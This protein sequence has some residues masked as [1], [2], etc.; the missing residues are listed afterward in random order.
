MSVACANAK[1]A[2]GEAW[3]A[4]RS[5][6]PCAKCVAQGAGAGAG[7]Y[8]QQGRKHESSWQD[9]HQLLHI[10]RQESMVAIDRNEV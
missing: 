7:A 9:A 3:H 1:W 4:C 10:R 2:E 8:T 6:V 5:A